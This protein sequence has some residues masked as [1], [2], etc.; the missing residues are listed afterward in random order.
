MFNGTVLFL[1]KT[2]LLPQSRG[3]KHVAI[4]DF[5]L[6]TLDEVVKSDLVVY[7]DDKKNPTILKNRYGLKK[8]VS[9]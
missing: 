3:K 1:N 7:H 6:G 2:D 8:T 5:A 4:G 9:V